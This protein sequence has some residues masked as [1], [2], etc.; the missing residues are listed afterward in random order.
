VDENG[1]NVSKWLAVTKTR[2]F[3]L[4]TICIYTPIVKYSSMTSLT[5]KEN[6]IIV[7]I[8]SCNMSW[9]SVRALLLLLL[10]TAIEF[11]LC[12]SSPYTS[13]K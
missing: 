11:S 4:I 10:L 1:S 8:I 7:V 13:N 2:V 3:R 12:V 9:A 6:N 5:T